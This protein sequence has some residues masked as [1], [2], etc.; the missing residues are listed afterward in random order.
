MLTPG[1]DH[2][3]TVTPAKTRWRAAYANHVIADTGE[4]LIVEESGR[5]AVVYFPREDVSM[6]YFARTDRTTHCP[7]KGDAGYYSILMDGKLTEN[8]VWTYEEPFPAA[9]RIRGRLAFDP[10]QIEVYAY[11]NPAA[12]PAEGRTFEAERAA[13]DPVVQHTDTGA[14]YSQGEHWEPTVDQ[15]E[16][17]IMPTPGEGGLA[18]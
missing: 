8:A 7:Y 3:I 9:E 10:D 16:P 1:P 15:P 5:G 18:R 14:G 2:Q 6:E 13:V 12:R 11:D 4:A 17:R